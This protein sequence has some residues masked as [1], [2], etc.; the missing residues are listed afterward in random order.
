M[1]LMTNS[2]LLKSKITEC[3]IPITFL[4]DK[5]GITREGL[6][7]KLNGKTEFK[8]SEIAALTKVLNLSNAERNKI[9][10]AN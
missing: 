6:Y 5:I 9:F 3:G 10:F 4:A 7:N 1:T 8:A 2:E